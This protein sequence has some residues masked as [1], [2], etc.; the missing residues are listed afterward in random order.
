M[1]GLLVGTAQITDYPPS[2]H[3][4]IGLISCCTHLLIYILQTQKNNQL[5]TL[6]VKKKNPKLLLVRAKQQRLSVLVKV[7]RSQVMWSRIG[8]SD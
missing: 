1:Y 8:V 3:L 2:A 6:P 5:V 4:C 7:R